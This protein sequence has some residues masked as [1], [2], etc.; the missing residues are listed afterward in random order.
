MKYGSSER[1]ISTVK[2]EDLILTS[3]KKFLES[4]KIFD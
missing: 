3:T 4:P 1:N 2:R